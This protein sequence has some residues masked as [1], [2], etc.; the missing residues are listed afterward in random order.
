MYN[1]NQNTT[2]HH[3]GGCPKCG[4]TSTSQGSVAMTSAGLA[5]M[6]DVQNN[7]FVTISCNNCGYTEF[8]K[9]MNN[10]GMD[11]ID[12]FFGG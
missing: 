10:G 11:F 2:T 4:H 3:T 1:N 5:R 8:Y 7:Q 12:L 9:Q 6:F